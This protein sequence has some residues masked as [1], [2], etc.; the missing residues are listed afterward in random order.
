VLVATEAGRGFACES[1]CRRNLF[2]RMPAAGTDPVTVAPRFRQHR[3]YDAGTP[4]RAFKLRPRSPAIGA[5]ARIPAGATRDF[6]GNRVARS[7]R[8]D[9]G[10]FQ[11]R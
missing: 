9:I 5:G 7:G 3:P 8:P 11:I 2:F 6:F 10:F 4:P 1:G